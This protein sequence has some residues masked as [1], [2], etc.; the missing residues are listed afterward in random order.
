MKEGSPAWYV[1]VFVI[2]AAAGFLFYWLVDGFE[3]KRGQLLAALVW[4]V[5]GLVTARYFLRKNR[6]TG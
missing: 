6:P 5:I 4:G 2:S 3:F 1:V